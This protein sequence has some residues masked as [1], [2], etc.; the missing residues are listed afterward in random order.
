M[1]KLLVLHI[2]TIY[3]VVKKVPYFLCDLKINWGTTHNS[4]GCNS[5]FIQCWYQ[6][7]LSW[8]M[9]VPC[10]VFMTNKK[11]GNS[12]SQSI[13]TEVLVF[14]PVFAKYVEPLRRPHRN[15]DW[16]IWALPVQVN[17]PRLWNPSPK[18]ITVLLKFS[19]K[20]FNS[21]ALSV[22]IWR[23]G[24]APVIRLKM[25]ISGRHAHIHTDKTD[26]SR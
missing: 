15:S 16:I 22:T 26:I 5:Q 2:K 18:A 8:C 12:D 1:A 25:A 10:F 4:L 20:S 3:R 23:Y 13:R 11:L 9:W 24:Y 21:L 7:I 17:R 14:E 6:T 19:R